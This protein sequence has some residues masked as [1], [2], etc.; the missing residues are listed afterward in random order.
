[1]R[2]LGWDAELRHHVSEREAYRDAKSI[3]GRA[4]MRWRCYDVGYP[5]R[6]LTEGLRWAEAY[7]RCL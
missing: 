4:K 7:R 3:S 2:D 6:L 5:F 1:M